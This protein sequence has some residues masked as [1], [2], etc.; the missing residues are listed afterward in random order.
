MGPWQPTA[1]PWVSIDMI[2]IGKPFQNRSTEW[3]SPT[4]HAVQ[5][6][7]I[8]ESPKLSTSYSNQIVRNV[9]TLVQ[10]SSNLS[11]TCK[12]HPRTPNPV[13][14]NPLDRDTKVRRQ[15]RQVWSPLDA[16]GH[17]TQRMTSVWF[18]VE[19]PFGPKVV[20][21]VVWWDFTVKQLWFPRDFYD[22]LWWNMVVFMGFYDEDW[23]LFFWILP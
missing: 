4:W 13:P 7:P 17:G 16:A 6:K 9:R 8:Q 1:G 18:W 11:K 12:N 2:D 20:V 10:N 14:K 19:E 3:V 5:P 22:I 15:Q 23:W 21:M